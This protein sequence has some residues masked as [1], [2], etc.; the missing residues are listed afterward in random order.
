MRTQAE[1]GTAPFQRG[2]EGKGLS[3]KAWETV[4][5]PFKTAALNHSAP[6]LEAESSYF[7]ADYAR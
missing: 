4:G 2:T 3:R 5:S 1:G 6:R 7:T